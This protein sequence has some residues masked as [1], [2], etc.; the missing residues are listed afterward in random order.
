VRKPDDIRK[1]EA[2]GTAPMTALGLA[3]ALKFHQAVGAA[4][5]AARVKYLT[6]RWA[7]PLLADE[8]FEFRTSFAPGM[9]NGIA[10]VHLKG[11]SSFDVWE[12]LF[13]REKILT[14]NVARR[15]Q[16]FHGIRVSPGIFNTVEEI[17]RFTAAMRRIADERP[18]RI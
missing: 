15:T 13:R 7:E 9:S 16:E 17:D 8:R 11:T 5:Y 10:V 2:I 1:F 18:G 14:F 6:Q 12:R 3:E 4:P